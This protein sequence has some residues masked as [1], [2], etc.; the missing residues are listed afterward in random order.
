METILPRFGKVCENCC[1]NFLILGKYVKI[2]KLQNFGS[3]KIFILFIPNLQFPFDIAICGETQQ[4]VA[5]RVTQVVA[6]LKQK[7]FLVNDRKTQVSWEGP[8]EVLGMQ[9]SQSQG[10]LRFPKRRI[11]AILNALRNNPMNT[12]R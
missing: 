1:I 8:I 4:A 12:H 6:A 5:G 9:C 3:H 2:S 11:E 10:T 7:G